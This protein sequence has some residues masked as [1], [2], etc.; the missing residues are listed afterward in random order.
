MGGTPERGEVPSQYA[1]Q[2]AQ[3]KEN[4]RGGSPRGFRMKA[5]HPS[6]GGNNADAGE[7]VPLE[8]VRAYKSGPTIRRADQR[9]EEG[10]RIRQV[11]QQ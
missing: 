1:G 6:Y 9:G 10:E 11:I 5:I 4:P 3:K 7:T 2:T 8:K